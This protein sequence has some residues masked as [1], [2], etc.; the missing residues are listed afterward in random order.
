[1]SRQFWTEEELDAVRSGIPWSDFHARFP[2]RTY[3]SW[4]VKR[5]RVSDYTFERPH[6]DDPACWCKPRIVHVG[7]GA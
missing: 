6:A 7:V 4:E 5:R 1:M 2:W 3:D